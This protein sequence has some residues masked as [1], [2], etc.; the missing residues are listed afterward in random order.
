MM[1]MCIFFL[2]IQVIGMSMRRFVL[3]FG[4]FILLVRDV[5]RD[6]RCYFEDVCVGMDL[7]SFVVL[8]AGRWTCHMQ[9]R[10]VVKSGEVIG[11]NED[12]YL[13]PLMYRY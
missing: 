6:A 4:N 2:C 8:V 10:H 7:L 11:F 1:S 9:R 12:L 3:M 5:T 13:S